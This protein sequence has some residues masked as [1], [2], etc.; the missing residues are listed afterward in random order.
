MASGTR[1]LNPIIIQTLTAGEALAAHRVVIWH[2]TTAGTVSY[3][4]GAADLQVVGVTMTAAA[5]GADVDVCRLGTCL[6][7]VNGTTDIAAGDAVEVEGTDGMGVKR[8]LSDGTT[9]REIIGTADEAGTEDGDEIVVF[10][11]RMPFAFTS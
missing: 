3:P 6:L 4:A 7:T 8:A 5:S 9:L 2:S 11:G 1:H 10:V